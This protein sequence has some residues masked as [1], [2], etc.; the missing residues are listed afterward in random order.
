[1]K[2]R[3]VLL[4]IKLKKITSNKKQETN[5][6]KFISGAKLITWRWSSTYGS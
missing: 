2:E 6:S 5:T 1:M 3:T 4:I